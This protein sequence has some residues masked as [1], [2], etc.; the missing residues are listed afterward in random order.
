MRVADADGR[1][2]V[3]VELRDPA[4]QDRRRVGE[5]GELPVVGHVAALQPLG[6]G[7]DLVGLLLRVVGQRRIQLGL[8]VE[9]LYERLELRR[10][11]AVGL[12]DAE[13]VVVVVVSVDS[14]IFPVG[15]LEAL[16]SVPDAVDRA[17]AEGLDL[18]GLDG[19]VEDGLAVLGEHVGV[20]GVGIVAGLARDVADPL[21]G[22]GP[23]V[24]R[25][26]QRG[27]AE[28][29]LVGVRELE[30]VGYG[31]R[32]AG[33]VG[34]EG[35]GDDRGDDLLEVI[36]VIGLPGA[37]VL[38]VVGVGAGVPVVDAA[39][40][41]RLRDGPGGAGGRARELVD[42]LVVGR[43]GVDL[44][45]EGDHVGRDA[46]QTADAVEA[47][48]GGRT[49]LAAPRIREPIGH[50]DHR[51][52]ATDGVVLD[53]AHERE[54][55]GRTVV[56]EGLVGHD[57]RR[58]GAEDLAGLLVVVDDILDQADGVLERRAG[59]GVGAAGE[60]LG[61]HG[62]EHEPGVV[63]VRGALV[64]ERDRVVCL[65]S[66]G[67]ERR[68]EGGVGRPV[69]ASGAEPDQVAGV[70]GLVGVHALAVLTPLGVAEAVV[71]EGAVL[72]VARVTVDV[73]PVVEVATTDVV[74]LVGVVVAVEVTVRVLDDVALVR[75]VAIEV[76]AAADPA[77]K[78]LNL[79]AVVGRVAVRSLVGLGHVQRRIWERIVAV[80][81]DGEPA[82]V[83]VAQVGERAVVAAQRPRTL[84][85]E[86]VQ[87]VGLVAR[88]RL[89]AGL[90]VDVGLDPGEAVGLALDEGPVVDQGLAGLGDQPGMRHRGA[91]RCRRS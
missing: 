32:P 14:A 9:Q 4:D 87:D 83:V 33:D 80:V 76:A 11:R 63:D 41:A 90:V 89:V 13:H 70:A 30:V 57:H 34:A 37:V 44:G 78:E 65:D 84:S 52:R 10:R 60:V 58:L 8:R 47:L 62:I 59:A 85:P 31:R 6:H 20:V 66:G 5:A 19:L 45:G 69:V 64:L 18:L 1:Q 27:L 43:I 51:H 42:A 77:G 36:L 16:A 26:L 23:A 38:D 68:V 56:A 50:D 88:D 29:G 7:R 25:G 61:R 21:G 82:E 17:G 55:L 91:E 53:D 81:G 86:R 74:A 40:L 12:G 46:E 15:L 28:L 22:L 72:R 67:V 3:R 2:E 73:G 54:V 71:V 75:V 39:A 49:A 79:A 24:D 48:E 35:S